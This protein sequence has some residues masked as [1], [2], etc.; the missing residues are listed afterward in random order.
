[1]SLSPNIPDPSSEDRTEAPP[2]EVEAEQPEHPPRRIPNIGHALLF[3]SFTGF[4]LAISELLLLAI[5]GA[6]AIS[7]SGTLQVVHPKL[8]IAAE[9]ATYAA[10]LLASYFLFPL[11]WHRPFLD[12]LRWQ[13]IAGRNQAA[14]LISLGFILGVTSALVDSLIS[15]NKTPPIDQFFLKA[16]DAWVITFFGV[17][18]APIFEEICFR[19]FLV[20]AIAIAYDWLSIPRTPESHMRWQA[21]TSLTP[22]SLIFSGVVSSFLF[23][24]IHGAQVG[25]A[26]GAMIVLFSVSLILTFVRVKTESV[27]ASTLVHMAY[28]AFIFIVMIF[29]TGGYRHL[30]RMAH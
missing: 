9:G 17:I 8:Q 16:S 23:A 20:P 18:V 12:G 24:F 19:G 28:N 6:P 29:A 1:M 2:P 26:W 25:Y 10:T 21:T 11:L 3:I 14:R 15:N 4:L 27:A 5:Y 30:D 7:H 13:W 22:L